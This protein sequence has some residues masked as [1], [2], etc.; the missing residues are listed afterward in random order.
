MTK[1][2]RRRAAIYLRVSRGGQSVENQRPSVKRLAKNRKLR[3]VATY[4]ENVS[5][6]RA[7]PE[8]AEMMAAAHRSE[9][10][11][12]LVWALDR[13]GRSMTINLNAVLQ[14]DRAGV[15]V[16]SVQEPWLDMGGPVRPLLVAIFGWVAEQER[17]QIVA[18]T[19]A[20]LD[21]ARRKGIRIGRP[22]TRV[23]MDRAEKLRRDGLSIDEVA[24]KL[25]IPR[26]TMFRLFSL[27]KGP[28]SEGG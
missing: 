24:V 6:A 22:P 18:R 9:F 15:E 7:R 20:G 21:E 11:V 13:F 14:L 23:N 5:A 26:S 12:L 25:R 17:E 2:I 28:D 4:E 19:K 3:V 27:K 10:D 1:L 16:V 8:F